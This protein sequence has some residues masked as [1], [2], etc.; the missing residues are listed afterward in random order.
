MTW[1]QSFHDELFSETLLVRRDPEAREKE[2]QFLETTLHLNKK[3][4]ILDQCCGIGSLSVPLLEKGFS[5]V[6]VD[7]V[8]DYIEKANQEAQKLGKGQF[9]CEDARKFIYSN[10]QA[11]FNWW[12]GFGYFETDQE[13]QQVIEA[14][15][16]SLRSGGYY[17]L[18]L[19]HPAGVLRHFK[20]VMITEYSTKFG[21]V[22][23]TRN[24]E[25]DLY[26]GRMEKDWIYSQEG[27]ELQRHHSSLRIYY[28]HEIAAMF[29]KIGFRDVQLF[30]NTR[31]EPLNIDHL[32]C[33]CIGR[34]P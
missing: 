15:F 22:T 16:Q 5:M 13:N 4:P 2:L 34:K 29:Q 14:A 23:L 21:V 19:L 20:P 9:F 25:F 8:P 18:D 12:T 26:N 24:T 1:L 33:I 31:L 11:V 32:R 7:I 3:E 6:G 27:K 30:G 28:A 10:C 17:L